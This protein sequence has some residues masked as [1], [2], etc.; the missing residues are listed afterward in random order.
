MAEF[1][2]VM[3]TVSAAGAVLISLVFIALILTSEE[4]RKLAF[5]WEFAVAL[6]AISLP[7]SILISQ[8]YHA[9]FSK[10]GFK[11]MNLNM[12]YSGKRVNMHKIDVAID[13]L[14]WK[15]GKG[16]KEWFVIQKRATAFHLFNMLRSVSI[17][18]L[19]SYT[20]SLV[21]NQLFGTL[22]IFWLGAGLV[23]G[24]VVSCCI[25]FWLSCREIWEVWMLLDRKIVKDIEP[26][27]D[28]WI[29][30]EKESFA[31]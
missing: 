31:T 29:K 24:V 18:F 9:F 10:F 11:K 30:D 27:L 2:E 20:L 3:P 17:S 1:R 6:V 19:F 28:S 14:S 7:L 23:Y 8:I 25:L 5:N 22:S 4:T 12:K 15:N 16:D 13:Y 26:E 21:W